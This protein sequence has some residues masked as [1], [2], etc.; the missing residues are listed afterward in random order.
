MSVYDRCGVPDRSRRVRKKTQDGRRLRRNERRWIVERFFA[1]IQPCASF[2]SS[3]EI[4]S[5]RM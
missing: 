3:F 5:A 2:S 4:G 1:W